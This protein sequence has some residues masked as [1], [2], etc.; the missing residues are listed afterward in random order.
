[1]LTPVIL[2]GGV[3]SRLWPLSREHYPKQLLAL[4]GANSLLQ[5]TI[6]RLA[7]ISE[8]AKPLVVCNEK[9][10]FL[11]AEQ[12]QNIGIE[13]ANI[14]L[15]PEG[16]NTAPAVAVAAFAALAKDPEAILMVLPADHLIADA[17]KFCQAIESGIQLAEAN[18]LVTFGIVPNSPETGYG[19]INASDSIEDT[20]AL[21][22]ESFVEKPDLATAQQYLESGEYYWNSGMFLFKASK[23]LQELEK[24]APDILGTCRL[25]IDNALEDKDFLR[26]DSGAFK[27][28]TSNSIDYSVM[29]HT[30]A[31]VVI[32]LDAGWND[33]GAWSSLWE[34][35]EQDDAGNVTL[36][37]VLTDNVTNSYLRAEHRLL[38]A[39]GIQD[40]TVIETADAVLV[41]H[42][43]KVQ[44]VKRI[45]SQL[46]ATQR[47]ETEL[48]RKVYRPWGYYETV[49]VE[50]RFQVK[51]ITVNPGSSLSLQMHYHRS[52]HWV[53][54]Q[55]TA[56]ITK[57]DEVFVLTENQSTYIPIGTKHRLENQGRIPLEII[58]IQS[59]SYLGEDDIV[60]YE[61]AYGRDS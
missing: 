15:E 12:L 25:A 59:G 21:S 44:D 45:V 33:V 55:G 24:F 38:A 11:V 57:N 46:K 49:D 56:K 36:G 39:V 1:M 50:E 61:D 27:A 37:D 17:T 8:Q 32:P 31:A 14:I 47:S 53:I 16:R 51:R 3:G 35:S 10:R 22:V 34:V 20:I 2:S 42:K 30:N 26:L 54:V 58:E 29:E 7:E 48:H 5:N 13:P 52:E 4:V 18:Y 28:C 9:H 40:L 23:Y 19:Y 43:D 41:A 6:L 60:R